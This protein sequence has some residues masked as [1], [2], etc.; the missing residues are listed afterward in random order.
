[1]HSLNALFQR[2][3]FDVADMDAICTQLAPDKLI[4]PHRSLFGTGNYDAN[5]LMAAL[6]RK[7][8]DVQ[9]FDSR[10]AAELSLEPSFL[11]PKKQSAEF[12]G[13]VVNNGQK[14]MMVFN[15]RHWLTIKRIDGVWFNLDSKMKCPQRLEEEELLSWLVSACQND[16]ELMICRKRKVQKR[17][18]QKR[19][20]RN[21]RKRRVQK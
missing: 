11:S 13:F 4:N 3:E 18:S 14:R 21:S 12:L 8:V 19:N 17:D 2:K 16:A 15:R 7:G 1:M 6:D 5:V 9:W 10:K 20:S